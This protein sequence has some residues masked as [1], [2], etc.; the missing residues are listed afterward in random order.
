MHMMCVCVCISLHDQ[1]EADAK[2]K[3]EEE[4]RAKIAEKKRVC[5]L[6]K[7]RNVCSFRPIHA[8]TLVHNA[9]THVHT[10]VITAYIAEG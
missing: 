4:R 1:A 3:R 8:Y 5:G 6:R 2:R 9:H 7:T 10:R